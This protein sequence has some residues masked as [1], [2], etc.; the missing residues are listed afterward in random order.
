MA[1]EILNTLKLK[2][3]KGGRNT[4]KKKPRKL[5]EKTGV[6]KASR[7]ELCKEKGV[8]EEN[9]DL[10]KEYQGEGGKKFVGGGAWSSFF[11]MFRRKP[12]SEENNMESESETISPELKDKLHQSLHRKSNNEEEVL[13]LA[14][15]LTPENINDSIDD[16]GTTLLH[17]ACRK[18]YLNLA[19]YL[20][21]NGAYVNVKDT[22][23]ENTP[24]HDAIMWNY[25]DEKKDEKK[26]LVITLIYNVDFQMWKINTKNRANESPIFHAYPNKDILEILLDAGANVTNDYNINGKMIWEN[27][28]GDLHYC[29]EGNDELCEYGFEKTFKMIQML[30]EN[31][32]EELPEE[33][34]ELYNKAKQRYNEKSAAKNLADLP[35]DVANITSE[36]LGGTATP[37]KRFTR[38]RQHRTLA[39]RKYLF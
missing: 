3:K 34:I 36:F 9:E 7:S 29:M 25:S 26:E 4:L 19:V 39:H 14:K 35:Q 33:Y 22:F 16:D 11:K 2:T 17:Y 38:R 12:K 24:L 1:K 21:E 28:M 23:Y 10:I 32:Q 27:P 30:K 31:C 20:L 6:K 18:L 8:C 37:K 5:R 15:Q 13:E